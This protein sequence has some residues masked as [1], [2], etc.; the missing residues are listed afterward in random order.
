METVIALLEELAMRFHKPHDLIQLMDRETVV[1]RHA[2]RME[3]VLRLITCPLDM[4]MGR[5]IALV[6]IEMEPITLQA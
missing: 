5:F 4:N 6:G 2:K 1:G 3:P